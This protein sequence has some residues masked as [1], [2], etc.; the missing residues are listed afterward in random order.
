MTQ[1]SPYGIGAGRMVSATSSDEDE[2]ARQRRLAASRSSEQARKGAAMREQLVQAERAAALS[3]ARQRQQQQ[4]EQAA[5]VRR[6]R[7]AGTGAT[8]ITDER[9]SATPESELARPAASA[10]GSG[11]REP[12]PVD[13]VPKRRDDDRLP[14]PADEMP[15][16]SATPATL[17]SG[18]IDE[19]PAWRSQRFPTDAEQRLVSLQQAI[20]Q[21]RLSSTAD[22]REA[23]EALAGSLEF[24]QGY[25]EAGTAADGSR[26][27][28]VRIIDD[29]LQEVAVMMSAIASPQAG[30]VPV[31][32]AVATAGSEALRLTVSVA[33]RRSR[34]GEGVESVKAAGK[35]AD[36]E[37]AVAATIGG[38]SLAVPPAAVEFPGA[39][40][41]S[42]ER[43]SDKRRSE[44]PVS[45]AVR[46]I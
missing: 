31:T 5:A 17:I 29:L 37:E 40:A 36:E 14:L 12:Q 34:R 27:R 43:D 13:G 3:E 16:P 26:Q 28:L 11:R 39:A 42:L 35:P 19:L 20:A 30:T 18:L 6:D 25:L 23:L 9:S 32:T 21:A 46:S 4:Q 44:T 2:R 15:R 38:V 22:S 10:L 24:A 33:T 1:I 8:K 45:V 7:Q 41:P